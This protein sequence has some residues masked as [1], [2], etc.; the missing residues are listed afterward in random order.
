MSQAVGAYVVYKQSL[1]MRFATEA[2]TCKSFY[3][4][5]GDLDM[6]QVE[7]DRVYA[8]LAGKGPITR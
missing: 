2:R 7:S 4:A 5:L 8:Y 3:R 1:R 6:N